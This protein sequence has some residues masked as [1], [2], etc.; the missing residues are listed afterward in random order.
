M[1]ELGLGDVD[2][3]A[4]QAHGPAADI[5]DNLTSTADHPHRPIGPHDPVLKVERLTGLE[6]VLQG[7]DKAIAIS[8][9]KSI[10]QLAE[11]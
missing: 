8:R 5:R 1:L 7:F 4:D 10:Q 3:R 11:R 6:R 2:S 9:G